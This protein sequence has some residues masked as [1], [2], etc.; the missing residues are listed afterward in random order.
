MLFKH[1][2]LNGIW[3]MERQSA[4]SYLPVVISYI[5]GNNRIA[6]RSEVPYLSARTGAEEITYSREMGSIDEFISST[7]EG[8]LLVIDISG[9]I[10][11]HNQACGPAGMATCASMLESAYRADNIRGIALKIDSGGGEGS[12]MRI[13][14]DAI[15]RRNKPVMAFIDDFAASAA[16]GIAAACDVVTANN[17]LAQIGSI[18]VYLSIADYSAKLEREGI[19][20]IEIY[21]PQSKD[22]NADVRGAIA[23]DKEAIAS[24]E[25][26]AG[27][28]CE[29]FINSVEKSRTEKLQKGRDVWGT[30]KV[31]FAGEALELGLIDSIDTFENFL[32]YLN[33]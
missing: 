25:K 28:F 15:G 31:F 13:M 14:Q 30:G 16:Y 10:T 4:E 12:A 3:L 24:L 20:L 18:G 22:K 32:D 23:G 21:A 33:I 26:T 1:K 8:S 27:I 29:S 5:Q 11:K 2:I 19:K 7:P 17:E 9:A 6:E